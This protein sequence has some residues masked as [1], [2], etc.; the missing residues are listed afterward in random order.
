M[1]YESESTV[2]GICGN[3]ESKLL[4]LSAQEQVLAGKLFQ[5]VSLRQRTN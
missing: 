1:E 3:Y 4:K 5:C 2:C